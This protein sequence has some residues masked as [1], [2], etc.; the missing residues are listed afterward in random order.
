VSEC[1]RGSIGASWS[2]GNADA[3][4][5]NLA[6][7]GVAWATLRNDFENSFA[8]SGRSGPICFKKKISEIQN[9]YVEIGAHEINL[10]KKNS[11]S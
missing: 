10:N 4:A 11:N 5:E 3:A 1:R 9:G 6:S 7:A 8:I 2:V